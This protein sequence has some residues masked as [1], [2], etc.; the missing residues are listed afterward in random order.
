M[1]V[2]I[3]FLVLILFPQQTLSTVASSKDIHDAVTFEASSGN[4][5]KSDKAVNLE[6]SI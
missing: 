3:L 5:G 1:N 6:V 4:E 2:K